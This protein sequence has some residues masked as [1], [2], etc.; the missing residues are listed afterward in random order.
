[1]GNS[2]SAS[3][4]TVPLNIDGKD[5]LQFIVTM[6]EAQEAGQMMEARA[7]DGQLMRFA[8][9]AVDPLSDF[10]VSYKRGGKGGQPPVDTDLMLAMH[11]GLEAEGV[12]RAQ[13]IDLLALLE[14]DIVLVL[15]DSGS[16]AIIDEG[17]SQSRWEELHDSVKLIIPLAAC[18]D[19]DGLD[20]HF[21]NRAA[22][23]QVSTLADKNFE[24]AM[25]KPP[26][27]GAPTP[28]TEKLRF[29]FD[30]RLR[31]ARVDPALGEKKVLFMIF[32]DGEPAGGRQAFIQTLR[33]VLENRDIQ[34]FCQI[35]ACTGR[36]SAELKWLDEIDEQ[37]Q[38]LDVTDDF[39]TEKKKAEASGS[40]NFTRG[41]WLL[42]AMLGGVLEKYDRDTPSGPS[43]A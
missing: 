22:I 8:A 19:K 33:D 40:T 20:V 29:I 3:G 5:I 21:L 1:M 7:P 10:P 39:I 30:E 35:M 16:M 24:E 42:K 18:F 43:Q 13:A 15:D 41:D 23:S 31:M 28:L 4:S 38:K 6:P 27:W 2:S 12:T 26:E 17:C 25:S 14:Y 36:D 11:V 34:C 37:I 9:P 32:T